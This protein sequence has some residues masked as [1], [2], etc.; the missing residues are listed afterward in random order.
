[1][2]GKIR[3]LLNR[4]G[5]YYARLSVPVAL[6]SIV[7]KRE[8]VEALGPDTRTAERKLSG[9][10]AK[11][12]NQLDAAL[13][14]SVSKKT[15]TKPLIGQR[16]N[17]RQIARA[18]YDSELALD[19]ANRDAGNANV[20]M[21]KISNETYSTKW[22]DDLNSIVAG[23]A[24]DNDIEVMLGGIFD[25]LT[26]RGHIQAVTGSPEWRKLARVLAGVQVEVI[27]RQAEL[28]HGN[29]NGTPEH[30][31]LKE[32]E[33]VP[34]DPLARR[35]L[36]P[37]SQK[38]LSDL[39]SDFLK[40]RNIGTGSQH[41]HSVSVRM[42]EEHL[43]ESRPIYKI[44]RRDVID[45]KNALLELPS[46]YTKRFPD[47]ALPDAIKANKKRKVPFPLLAA[48][49]VNSKWI[50]SLRALLNWC[51]QNDIIP[52]NP[53]SG[54][55][56]NFQTDKGKPPR[57][58][59]EPSDLAKIFAKPLF[60]RSKPWGEVQWS[61]VLSL[62]CGT[63]A[64][65]LAQVQLDS[66]RHEREILVMR[67]QEETKNGTS[68]RVIP[69]HSELV[70]LGFTDHVAA[71]RKKG[72]THLFPEWYS[73]GMNARKKAEIKAKDTGK[74]MTQNHHFPKF[75]P[76]KFNTTYKKEIGITDAK[77]VFHSFR[78]SF[79]TGLSQAGVS[80]DIRNSLS[81]HSDSSAGAAYVH[82]V[83]FTAL[84]DGI[85][86]LRFDGLNI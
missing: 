77:K 2:A 68:Q 43:G 70:R 65:E 24:N 28:N 35:I 25:E 30:P 15:P 55:K 53:A 36:G 27:K 46:N 60:D 82:D 56:A 66:I 48:R 19:R 79:K 81:G 67:V 16:L 9:V 58:N 69:I 51:V 42:F 73:D 75:I 11:M 33:P 26:S 34:D 18:F 20:R 40:E 21:N 54:I 41:E 63:R 74:P 3:H 49:T 1:M 39:V 17:D 31:L 10:V 13:A 38:P 4:G 47:V 78:H 57:V 14:Q 45:Y 76:R 59:F 32:A 80:K 12:Q 7:G 62:Y 71:L 8:L 86:K 5:R 64:S 44:T 72:A 85:E 61:Y 84:R 52:D 50:S 23:L 83:S 22:L 37:N 29:L 6:R